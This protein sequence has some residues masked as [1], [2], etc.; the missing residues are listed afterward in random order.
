ME[1][2]ALFDFDGR[3][4]G[5]KSGDA[6]IAWEWEMIFLSPPLLSSTGLEPK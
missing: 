2:L 6:K 3:E 5:R 4:G 1:W